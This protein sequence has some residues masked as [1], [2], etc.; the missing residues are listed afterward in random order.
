MV[1]RSKSGMRPEAAESGDM[2]ENA[3]RRGK[4]GIQG[5]M[6]FDG[7]RARSRAKRA[8]SIV[9]SGRQLFIDGDP[10]SGHDATP[11]Y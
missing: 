9:T 4:D 2:R 1:K 3:A 5:A 7:I 8:R 6:P 11:T 10:N